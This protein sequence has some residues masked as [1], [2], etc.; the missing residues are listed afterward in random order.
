MC[1]GARAAAARMCASYLIH[2]LLQS[3]LREVEAGNKHRHV[4]EQSGEHERAAEHRYRRDDELLNAHRCAERLAQQDGE[5]DVDVR[6]ID[7]CRGPRWRVWETM[8]LRK[9]RDE[10]ADGS[11]VVCALGVR[12]PHA[13]PSIR[14]GPWARS[15]YKLCVA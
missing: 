1:D 12:R 2:L 6:Q 9:G 5:C 13:P 3:R 8:V 14:L 10:G 7:L 4:T 15:R 11:R